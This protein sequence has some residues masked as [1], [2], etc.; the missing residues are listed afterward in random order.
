MCKKGKNMGLWL[1]C[2]V[3]NYGIRS[4][5]HDLLQ[6]SASIERPLKAAISL[7]SLEF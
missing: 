5:S 3:N 2:I 1:R 4:G 6:G 7:Q